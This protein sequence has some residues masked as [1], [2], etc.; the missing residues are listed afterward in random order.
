M[1]T[2][3]TILNAHFIRAHARRLSRRGENMMMH[4]SAGYATISSDTTVSG[5][6]RTADPLHT[7]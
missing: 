3:K 4:T 6:V 5:V 1:R 2:A 7:R